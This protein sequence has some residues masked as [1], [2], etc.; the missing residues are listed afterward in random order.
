MGVR[1]ECDLNRTGMRVQV[2]P[3]VPDQV[4]SL[5]ELGGSSMRIEQSRKLMTRAELVRFC[6]IQSCINCK[7][8]QNLRTFY[9]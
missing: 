8:I 6:E 4:A 1:A 3:P 9:Q 2:P 5:Q 7:P